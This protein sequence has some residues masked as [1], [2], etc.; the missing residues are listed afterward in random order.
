MSETDRI[1]ASKGQPKISNEVL[2]SIASLTI[3]SHVREKHPSVIPCQ[4]HAVSAMNCMLVPA[5]S[6]QPTHQSQMIIIDIC[7]RAEILS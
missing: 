2:M 5:E 3:I 4:L 7:F 6:S 1:C